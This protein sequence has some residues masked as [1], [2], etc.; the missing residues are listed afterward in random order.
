[1]RIVFVFFLFLDVV[2]IGCD[3]EKENNSMELPNILWITVEDMSPNLGCYDDPHAHT[4]N[5]DIFASKGVLYQNAFAT[6]PVCAPARSTIITGMYAYSLGSH[7]MRCKGRFPDAFGYYPQ[8]LRKA[9][10]YCINNHKEDYNLQ[11]SSENIWD[12]SGKKAHWRNRPDH[13]TPFFAV[14]NLHTTHESRVNNPESHRKAIENVPPELLKHAGDVPLPPYYPDTEPV[15]KL[16]ARYYNNI[17]AMD[18]QV[19]QLLTQLKKDGLEESTIVIY[20][21]DHGAGIPVYKRWLFDTG[22]KVPLL[23]YAPEQYRHLI[24]HEM[25]SSTGEMVSFVD[26][27][28]TVLNLAGVDVPGHMQGR[29]FLGE[30]LTPERQ[31]IHAGRD[32][33]DERYD[34]QRVVRD[35]QYKYIRYYEA[36]KPYVQYMNT[37]EKGEI[38][39][40]IRKAD[41]AGTL[42]DAGKALMV[43]EKPLEALYDLKNDPYELKNLADDPTYTEKLIEL[44]TAHEHWTDSIRDTGLIPETIIRRWERESDMPVY[45]IM[46]HKNIPIADIRKMAFMRDPGLLAGGVNHKNEAV[47][48][49]ALIGLGNLFANAEDLNISDR[50]DELQGDPVP[51]VRIALARLFCRTGMVNEGLE[52]LVRE[53]KHN[54]EWVR[55]GAAQVLDEIGDVARPAIGDLQNVMDDKNKYVV[56]VANHALNQMLGTTHV[57]R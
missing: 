48:Y 15:R 12:D 26:L 4:P 46:R 23:V 7:H 55:L 44:R 10:Y 18:M 14:F 40:A 37:P 47:R 6:A 53:L 22:L 34:M 54:D 24:P 1:M 2:L 13:D 52:I 30:E 50:L 38:M 17:T 25:K 20:Y 36:Y 42:P 57:V 51:I 32:R 27:A 3:P 49:W 21:S 5:L 29:A 8:Y 41:E 19:G 33:M 45:S 28:P 11:Y 39:K 43:D 31:Y 16:W 9:G 35:T 56:R